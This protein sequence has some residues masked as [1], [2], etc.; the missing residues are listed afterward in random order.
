MRA[1]IARHLSFAHE[2]TPIE[3]VYALDLE[4]LLDPAI[5][6]FSARL[7]GTIVGM[8]AIKQLDAHHGEIK[9]MHTAA[10]VRGQG[11]GRAILDHLVAEARARGYQRVS[12]E[13]G[14]MDAFG[15]ARALYAAAGS[16]PCE[17]FGDYPL[18]ASSA[19]MT[20]RLD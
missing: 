11:V 14:T 12:L 9:S 1:L 16:E 8:G 2:H 3:D 17:R 13:T 15:P 18:D 6:F 7:D 4:G 19:F 20:L 5:S 10:E